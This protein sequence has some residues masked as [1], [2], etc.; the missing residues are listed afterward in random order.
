[1][2]KSDLV[3]SMIEKNYP[4]INELI[5]NSEISEDVVKEYIEYCDNQYIHAGYKR[6][7]WF[8][9]YK[10]LKQKCKTKGIESIL[11][12]SDV[13]NVKKKHQDGDSRNGYPDYDYIEVETLYGKFE[14]QKSKTIVDI[15]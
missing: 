7:V 14:Y 13:L 15:D 12:R 8:K 6:Y 10:E 3:L 4:D 2:K 9:V 5:N 11:F 1:M